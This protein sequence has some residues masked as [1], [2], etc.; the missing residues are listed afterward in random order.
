MAPLVIFASGMIMLAISTI[1][2]PAIGTAATQLQSDTSSIS[3]YYWG[4]SWA[5]GST[6]LIL[7]MVGIFCILISAAIAWL[8]R[9]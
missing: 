4:F 7:F 3:S 1:F 8:Q 2:Y 9:R 5:M 6:R